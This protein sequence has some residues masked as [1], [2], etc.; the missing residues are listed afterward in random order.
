MAQIYRLF[1]IYQ[2]KKNYLGKFYDGGKN[3]KEVFI[4]ANVLIAQR[5]KGAKFV[6][7]SS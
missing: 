6:F 1:P 2:F 3:Y 7:L 5:R 4:F